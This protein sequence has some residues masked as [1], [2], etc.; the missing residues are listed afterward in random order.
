M[1]FLADK[2]ER[3]IILITILL[4]FLVYL[5]G[6]FPEGIVDSAKYAAIAREIFESGDPIHLKIRGEPYM[7]KPPLLFWLAALSFKIFGVSITAFKIPNLI[8]SLWGVYA[9]YRLGEMAYGKQAGLLAAAIYA[10]SE[11]FLLFVM[12]VHTDLLLTTF[13]TTGVWLLAVY[14]NNGKAV[15]FITGFISIG[16]AMISKGALGL[17][18]P[19]FA[20]GGYLLIKRDFKNFFSLKWLLA[21][22]ILAVI[23]YPFLKGVYDQFGKE[24]IIFYFWSNNIDR[25]KG[26]YS[27]GRHD[28]LFS[29]HTLL[30]LFLP[31]SVFSFMAFFRDFKH[32]WKSKFRI[33]NHF[34]GL[35]YSVILVLALI[36]SVSSQQAPHYLLPLIPFISILTARFITGVCTSEERSHRSYLKTMIIIRNLVVAMLSLASV[37]VAFYFLPVKK[38]LII[39]ML[40]IMLVLIIYSSLF[41]KES[42]GR[43]VIPLLISIILTA[44]VTNTVYMP[45]AMKHHG[46]IQASYLYNDLA[47]PGEILYTLDYYQFE[48]YFYPDP[49]S[50]LL[51][52]EQLNEVLAKG[53]CWIVTPES[54]YKAILD[55]GVARLKEKHVLQHVQL[56][57]ISFRFLNPAT[58]AETLSDVYLLRI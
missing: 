28:Y 53:N 56:T 51:Y 13:I 27:Q 37:A 45:A 39:I 8:I 22:P 19:A 57:N 1:L 49:V 25:I 36:V 58:R 32:W 16:L 38:P 15:Y 21:I 20:I 55:S 52:Y 30:Y 23:L 50:E 12:D 24:G 5:T 46:F 18:I 4:V 31:W 54:G 41:I 34:D 17:A 3:F 40:C 42:P 2:R 9:V 48:T 44:F 14:L 35:F 11:A 33:S 29:V 43:L 6:L 7:H 47:S 10:V 26:D